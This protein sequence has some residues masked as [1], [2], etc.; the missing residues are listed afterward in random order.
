MNTQGG[1]VGDDSS[2]LMNK[3]PE[4]PPSHWG[5]LTTDRMES[6]AYLR[7]FFGVKIANISKESKKDERKS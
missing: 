6:P 2:P 4:A 7:F 5:V 3:V 1:R